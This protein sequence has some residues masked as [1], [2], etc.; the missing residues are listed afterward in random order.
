VQDASWLLVTAVVTDDN[1]PGLVDG[2]AQ[3][4]A[5]VTRAA[6]A[7]VLDTWHALGMRGTAS[8]DVEL[9]AVFGPAS[10]TFPLRPDAARGGHYQTPLYRY[11]GMGAVAAVVPPVALGIAR[12]ALDAVRALATGKTPFGS[13]TRLFQR[14]VAQAA[15]ARAGSIVRAARLLLYDTLI[16]AWVR[17]VAGEPTTLDQRAELLLA[18]TYAV[19]AAVSA[20]DIAYGMA[21]TS[22]ISA[23]NPLG[24]APEFGLIAF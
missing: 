6:D 9:A 20:V 8:R 7:A 14:A 18:A 12:A 21:G 16:G 11:P 2:V 15:L 17:T 4:I 23:I 19:D 13:T 3:I 22:A 5:V 24:V 1:Q 10:R